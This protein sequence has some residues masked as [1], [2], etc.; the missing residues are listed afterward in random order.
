VLAQLLRHRGI[1]A[2]AE[3]A[4]ALSMSKSFSLELADTSLACVCYLGQPS[5]AKIHHTVRGLS[6]RTDGRRILFTLLGTEAPKSVESAI[7]A[8]ATGGSFAATLEAVVKAISEQPVDASGR[9]KTAAA[10]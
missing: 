2:T 6:K 10:V 5:N 1:G 8:L 4:N 3:K 9:A 7:G